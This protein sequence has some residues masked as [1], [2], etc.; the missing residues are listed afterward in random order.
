MRTEQGLPARDGNLRD[1]RRMKAGLSRTLI[2]VSYSV[3]MVSNSNLLL[4][5]IYI[6][7]EPQP[8]ATVKCEGDK[9]QG[10]PEIGFWCYTKPDNAQ[11]QENDIEQSG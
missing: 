3:V 5:T 8:V 10:Q 1:T 7:I 6:L 9:W 4:I 2:N 11:P